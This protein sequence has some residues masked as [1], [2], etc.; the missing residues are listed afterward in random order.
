[1]LDNSL[2]KVRDYADQ[3]DKELYELENKYNILGQDR[4]IIET[5]LIKELDNLR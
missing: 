4:E 2:R 1:M 3:R 5:R